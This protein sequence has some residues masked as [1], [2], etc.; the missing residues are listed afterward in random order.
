MKKLLKRI[1]SAAVA[2]S[3]VFAMSMTA[4]ADN[5]TVKKTIIEQKVSAKGSYSNWDGVSN[6][7]QF[8]GSN[9][10]FCFAYDGDKY[11]TVVRTNS[12][13]STLKKKIQLEKKHPLFGTVTCDSDGNYYLVTGE[14]NKSGSRNTDTI[15]ISKYNKNGT[16]IKTVGDNGRSSLASYYDDS[17]NTSIPFDAGNC[18][19]AINGDIIAVNYAREMYSGHQ[20]N[21]LFAVNIKTMTKVSLGVWYNSHSFAQRA[22]PF[23]NGFVFASEGDCYDRAFTIYA[24]DLD[25]KRDKGTAYEE[26]IFHFWVKQ[27]TLDAYNMFVLNEN[28]AHMG[29]L[30]AVNDKTVALVGT[31]AKSLNSNAANENEQLFVQIFNPLTDMSK[32]SAFVTT[33]TRS[34]KGGGNGDESVT[35]YGVKWLTN[36]DKASVSN[37]QIVSAGSGKIVILFEKYLSGKYQGVYY[38]VLDSSGKVLTKA[39]RFSSEAR[40]N[41]CVM[42]VYTG[43]KIYWASNKNNDKKNIYVNIL[44]LT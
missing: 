37:P 27:G 23:K 29:G 17:F 44:E 43:G 13:G 31:S 12:E 39:K 3:M 40:L 16:H 42:P 33:G 41:P 34:G 6:V 7:A 21:S 14:T 32:S 19:A 1:V 11:V 20:S 38:T 30:A 9:G 26:N 8:V 22:I 36:F 15:F 25:V 10:E 24:V 5:V 28:F 4:Y 18:D 2:A 35:D